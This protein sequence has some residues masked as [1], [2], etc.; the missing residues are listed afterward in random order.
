MLPSPKRRARA[1]IVAGA[2]VFLPLVLAGAGPLHAAGGAGPGAEEATVPA[3]SVSDCGLGRAAERPERLV[4]VVPGLSMRTAEWAPLLERLRAEEGYEPERAEW[5][6]F[7]HNLTTLSRG[8]LRTTARDLRS[9][10]DA[11]W[12]QRGGYDDVVIVGHSLGGLLARDAFTLAKGWDAGE[13]VG[14]VEWA[15]SV[16]R[17]VLFAGVNR[18]LDPER[19]WHWEVGHFVTTVLPVPLPKFAVEDAVRGSNFITNLRINWI[20]QFADDDHQPVVVQLLGSRDELVRDV[21]SDDVITFQRSGQLEVPFATHK[22]IIRVVGVEQ[23]EL[24]YAVIREAFLRVPPDDRPAWADSVSA[25]RILFLLHG[26]RAGTNDAWQ[27]DLR[28]VIRDSAHVWLPGNKVLVV[29]PAYGYFTALDF[30]RPAGRK[31]NIGWFQDQYTQI[32]ARNRKADADIIAH[33]NGTYMLGESLK[34]VRAMTFDHVV[35]AGS[36]LPTDYPWDE[37]IFRGQVGEVRND[38]ANGDWPVG[39]LARGLHGL[40]MDDVGTGG[41]EGFNG[42]ATHM[43]AYYK[44]GGH[45]AAFDSINIA[46]LA[47]SALLGR[48]YIVRDSL[49]VAK[50]GKLHLLSRATPW[51]V[52]LGAAAGA[53]YTW[54]YIRT[55]G[56]FDGD[57]ILDVGIGVSAV[58]LLLK[59]I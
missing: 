39:L 42:S 10:I 26:I 43:V 3:S 47:R 51:I 16:E 33:S 31:R 13:Y 14:A 46:P 18:G 5:L 55:D 50:R 53:Y 27:Q 37:V 52:R 41:F 1:P 44:T 35:L 11:Q 23:P 45:G 38:V 15:D 9:V 7:D 29:Q 48:P 4:V 56:D 17:I 59:I 22:D 58:Y 54:D 6:C 40:G 20:R 30:A 25:D 49:L 36:V 2:V 57:R 21:D 12:R 8:S 32:F 28:E 24:R 34:R 19:A